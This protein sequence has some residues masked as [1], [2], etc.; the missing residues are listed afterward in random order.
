MI[1]ALLFVLSA[2]L[3]ILVGARDWPSVLAGSLND[4]D[5]YMRLL[6][7]EQGIRAGHLLVAVTRDDS[8]A[9]VMVEWSRLLDMLLWLMAAPF[10]P[11]LG[12]HRALFVAGVALGP[13]GVGALGATLAWVAAPFA[14]RAYLWMAALAAALLPGL[15]TFAVPGVV[16]YHILLLVLITLTVGFSA[17]SW[18]G[19]WRMAICAGM[20]GGAAIWLTPETMPF[21]LMAFAAL[22][23]RW[24]EC[25]SW[26]VV[27][28]CAACFAGMLTLALALDPPQGGYGMP[29]VDRLSCVYVVLGFL[30]LLGALG[31]SALQRSRLRVT[32][33]VALMVVLF[34]VWIGLF[35]K[36]ALGPYGIIP[37]AEMKLFFGAIQ[38]A[39][40]VRGMA[41]ITFLLPGFLALAFALWR[42]LRERGWVWMYFALC[43]AVALGLGA[44]FV[45]FVGFSTAA[46]AVLLPIM[47]TR[48]SGLLAARPGLAGGFRLALLAAMFGLP[49]ISAAAAH[50]GLAVRGKTYPSCDLR[51]IGKLLAPVTGQVVLAPMEDT[52]ELLYRS[53]VETVGS[54]YQHGV[55]AYLRARAAW[56]AVPGLSEPPAVR[57]TRASYV[58]FCPRPGRYTP[59]ADLP[60]ATLWD[61][62]E[63]SAPPPWLRLLGQNEAGWRL[64]AIDA[65]TPPQVGADTPVV[66]G[67]DNG[68]PRSERTA[69]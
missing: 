62:L 1:F 48:L 31:L 42:A 6:R 25:P 29:E 67:N 58:L 45:L 12:W 37:K 24:I 46:A 51:T 2:G 3:N 49:E 28:G 23:F 41:L 64:Y 30:V 9:G 40:P 57:E 63:V 66:L 27:G 33:G 8:G 16:H 13:L 38:E 56:R 17:R 53:N 21:V 39:Q 4:P 52:P 50:P 60:P 14:R 22:F 55:P 11:W 54:L 59:V 19:D 20:S 15:A 18:H 69:R 5:S 43:Q 10:A 68:R 65:K 36:V 61:R 44:K 7:I 26:R 32:G 35:P 47:V 34:A